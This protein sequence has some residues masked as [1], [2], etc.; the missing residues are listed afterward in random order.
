[1]LLPPV[2][3]QPSQAYLLLLYEAYCNDSAEKITFKNSLENIFL[4]NF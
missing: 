2:S 4:L 1:M 3:P